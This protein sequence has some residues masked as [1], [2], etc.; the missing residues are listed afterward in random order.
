M[1]INWSAVFAP[2]PEP[3]VFDAEERGPESGI[4]VH[5]TS[6]WGDDFEIEAVSHFGHASMPLWCRATDSGVIP[7]YFFD[8]LPDLVNMVVNGNHPGG[9]WPYQTDLTG[10]QNGETGR[11]HWTRTNP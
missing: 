6:D 4:T 5:M 2:A 11:A 10:R 3:F 9:T 7:D 1:L 8:F